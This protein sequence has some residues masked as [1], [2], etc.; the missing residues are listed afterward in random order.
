MIRAPS[1]IKNWNEEQHLMEQLRKMWALVLATIIMW[2]SVVAIGQISSGEFVNGVAAIFALI[3]TI[4]LW[5][6][7]ATDYYGISMDDSESP[8]GKKNARKAEYEKPKRDAD[9]PNDDRVALLLSLLTPDERDAVRARLVDELS[10]DGEVVSLA[11]LL[12]EQQEQ[13]RTERGS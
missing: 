5:T 1:V 12:A 11:D 3:G 2:L 6:M 10:G 7:W 8:T 13:A 9:L 4:T